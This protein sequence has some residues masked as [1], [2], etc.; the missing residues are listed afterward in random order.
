MSKEAKTKITQV[1]RQFF[2]KA[3]LVI[4]ESR[5]VS[6]KVI[7]DPALNTPL[8]NKWFNLE[9]DE[10]EEI[11]ESL[12][13]WKSIEFPSE[14]PPPPL[15]V[16]TYLDLRDLGSKHNIYLTT[17]DTD[18]ND[19]LGGSSGATGPAEKQFKVTQ[20]GKRTEIVLER[21]IVQFIPP[22]DASADLVNWDDKDLQP[23]A[24]YKQAATLIRSL[25]TYAQILPVW[26]LRKKLNRSKL[27]VP[28]LRIG[29]RVLDGSQRLTSKGRIGLTKKLTDSLEELD[30]IYFPVLKTPF[31]SIKMSAS[32]RVECD[33]SILDTE[34]F[35]SNQFFMQDNSRAKRPPSSPSNFTLH[36]RQSTSSSTN[37]ASFPSPSRSSLEGSSSMASR[38]NVYRHHHA[39]QS[40]DLSNEPFITSP[41][42]FVARDRRL[43]SVSLRDSPMN[44]PLMTQLPHSHQGTPQSPSS[45]RPQVSLI[46]PF[47]T[48]SLSASPSDS[49]LSSRPQSF[50]R[51]TSN[52]SLAALR[53]PNRTMSNASTTSVGSYSRGQ[54]PENA[55]SSSVSSSK[56]SSAPKFSSSFGSRGTWNR[57]G[58]LSGAARP[59]RLST[60]LPG[61]LGSQ[62]SFGPSS[63][64]L[65]CEPEERDDDQG[66]NA[67]LHLVTNIGQT[68]SASHNSVLL[69]GTSSGSNS[70]FLLGSRNNINSN[71][72]SESDILSRFQNMKSS[73][74]ALSDSLLESASHNTNK[75]SESPTTTSTTSPFPIPNASPPQVNKAVSQHTP[76]VPSRLSEE[77]TA[78]DS[79][80]AYYYSHPRKQNSLSSLKV[81][82]EEIFSQEADIDEQKRRSSASKVNPLDIPVPSSKPFRRES[83]SMR[84]SHT[85]GYTDMQVIAKTSHHQSLGAVGGGAIFPGKELSSFRLKPA[86]STTIIGNV[87]GQ[88]Q[89]LSLSPVTTAAVTTTGGSRRNSPTTR[90]TYYYDNDNSDRTTSHRSDG[91]TAVGDDT[92]PD[93]DASQKY[94]SDDEDNDVFYFALNEGDVSGPNNGASD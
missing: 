34:D 8:V 47:K 14:V 63:S 53:I 26:T 69:S 48:P 83:V 29:C 37:P 84:N 15:V 39:K 12:R 38:N 16:E 94:N 27:T 60:E 77:F 52:S 59:K 43:S 19:V 55:I 67:F 41:T 87:T 62:G 93:D 79:F 33:F 57:S 90:F 42:E 49:S 24:I 36:R 74:S 22:D 68:Q 3:A 31:G 25:Y 1:I 7:K 73:H 23:T 86:A 76:S 89:Q 65:V 50:S 18:G 11:R 45:S 4:S 5:V 70:S 35:L 58:S 9:L 82:E 75:L 81:D 44:S 28:P 64:L 13:L 56:S 20:G 21:W 10:S 92:P 71:L 78:N 54:G 72:P 85:S 17:H 80:K 88:V 61:S 2:A 40:T 30:S 66:L 6:T 32:H 46:Q 51:T 91:E